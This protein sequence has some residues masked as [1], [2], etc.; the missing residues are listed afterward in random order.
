LLIACSGL[1]IANTINVASDLSGMADAAEVLTGLSSHVYV[2]VFG[3]AI[4][5]VIVRFRYYQ[6]A[7]ILKWLVVALFAYV[8][9]AFLIGPDWQ[10]VARDALAPSIPRV[11]KAGRHWWRSSA[12]L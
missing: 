7:R 2:V 11:R 9:T 12:R 4:G 10:Q 8:L 5:I 6:I 1:V 3:A